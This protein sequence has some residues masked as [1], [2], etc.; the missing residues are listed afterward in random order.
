MLLSRLCAVGFIAIL[1]AGQFVLSAPTDAERLQGTWEIVAVERKGSPDLRSVGYT[2]RLVGNEAHFNLPL[3]S[4]L[5]Y[6][7]APILPEKL[8][9]M[10]FS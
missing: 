8:R 4:P 7:V 6:T 10:A 2:L 9:M 1:F 3:D 5:T